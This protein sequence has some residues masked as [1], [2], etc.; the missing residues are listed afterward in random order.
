MER[1]TKN[2]ANNLPDGVQVFGD[3]VFINVG[4]RSPKWVC[5]LASTEAGSLMLCRIVDGMIYRG[6]SANSKAS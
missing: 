5:D 2:S 1:L 4:K 6:V 3:T